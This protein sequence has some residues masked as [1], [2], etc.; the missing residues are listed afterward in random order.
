MPF[1]QLDNPYGIDSVRLA[2][3]GSPALAHPDVRKIKNVN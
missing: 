2:I 1:K 3:D